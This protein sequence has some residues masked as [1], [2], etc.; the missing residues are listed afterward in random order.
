MR[1]GCVGRR[2]SLAAAVGLALCLGGCATPKSY[3]PIPVVG[4][5]Y[6]I[7]SGFRVVGYF[8]S[9]S[10]DPDQVQYRALTHINYAFLSP[11]ADGG[12]KSV[13]HPEKLELLVACAHAYGVRVL[14]SLGGGSDE[15]GSAF[16]AISADPRLVAAFCDSAM[17]MLSRYDLDG[18]DVDWEF[19]AAGDAEGFA[20][21]MHA[22]AER[23][24]AAHRL[25]TIA[26]SADDEHGRYVRDDVIADVDFLNIMAY[27]DGFGRPGAHHSTYGF[28]AAA[29]AYWLVDRGVP[30]DKTVI[31]LPFYG[32]SLVNR[33]SRSFK[34]I[35]AK[36]RE[37]PGKDV[38]G[39]FGYNGFGTV[40]A[41]TLDL[42]LAK[43]GGVMVWQLNQDASGE[44]SLLNAIFDAVKEPWQP[45][46]ATDR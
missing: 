8:P 30:A 27:D 6:R 32:R 10:G 5:E 38:S 33:H 42:A 34:A 16:E 37:A 15:K 19:P 40:R 41:K 7:P 44:F 43:G 4:F 1:P 35:F 46:S 28:A 36:D 39:E 17:A 23:L 13:D 20:G 9:W 22:L 18:I 11:G 21:L 29:Q 24:H 31:G 25:L 26:V 3:A 12:F 2:L 14:A 45:G